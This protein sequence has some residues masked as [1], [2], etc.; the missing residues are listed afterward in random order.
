MRGGTNATN[1]PTYPL[2]ISDWGEL[3]NGWNAQNL[4]VW[5]DAKNPTADVI[6]RLFIYVADNGTVQLVLEK[7]NLST[8]TSISNTTI[9]TL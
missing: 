6:G 7:K 1:Q 9:A 2:R 8:G 4:Y 3:S 5:L